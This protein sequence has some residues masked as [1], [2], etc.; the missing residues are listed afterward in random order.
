[1]VKADQDAAQGGEYVLISQMLITQ[2]YI[3]SL[4]TALTKS[5]EIAGF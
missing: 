4:N 1:M 5:F 2:I 3:A